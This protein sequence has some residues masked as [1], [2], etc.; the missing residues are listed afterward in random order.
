MTRRIHTRI[1]LTV[2]AAAA[3]AA[4]AA[5]S[6]VSGGDDGDG[7]GDCDSEVAEIRVVHAA[8]D[9]P[10][11]DVYVAGSAE[12]AIAQLAYGS[13]SGYLDVPAGAYQFEIRAAG[14][15]PGSVPVYTTDTLELEVGSRTT[16]VAAGLLDGTGANDQFR[17]LAIAEGFDA[18]AADAATIRVVHGGADAPTVALDLG[19]DGSVELEKLDR[20]ADTGTGGIQI[21]AETSAQVAI[22]AGHP[23]ARVTAFTVPPLARGSEVVVVATGLLAAEPR[24]GDGFALLAAIDDDAAL[25]RQNPQL[26]VLHAGPDAPAIDI[27]DGSQIVV[28][29]LS[30]GQ[31]SAP[32][33]LPPAADETYSLEIFA[34][35]TTGSGAPVSTLHAP[36]IE[37]GSEYMLVATG[38]LA[39]QGGEAA[40]EVI[41]FADGFATDDPHA[42]RLRVIHASPDAPAVDVSTVSGLVLDRPALVEQLSFGTAD[43][44]AGLGVPVAQLTVGVG[45]AG[46]TNALAA[47]D[48]ATA[49][50]QRALVVAAGSLG[51]AAG[52]QPFRL[53]A[54]DTSAPV[55]TAASLPAAH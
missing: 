21:P 2:F 50:G 53:I 17:V 27:T 47:F 32:L 7:D 10:S 30:F 48:L 42:A 20:F 35:G 11:V 38:F 3:L 9:A 15:D 39:P 52:R 25:I 49:P 51:A 13:S 23:L 55:W 36:A 41:S 24:D 46:A 12:P 54:I 33:Q 40:F 22:L 44:G 18:P 29:D 14:S 6:G 28:G 4:S 8:A 43:D 19:D 26:Y 1:T 34:A 31:L 37:A 45:A 16:A 5:C